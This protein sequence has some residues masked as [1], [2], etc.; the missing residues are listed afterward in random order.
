MRRVAHRCA[1]GPRRRRAPGAVVRAALV[2]GL[3]LLAGR[4]A[5]ADGP[6]ADAAAAPPG[7]PF[8]DYRS[9]APGHGHRI[10]IEDLPPPFATRSS[11]NGPRIVA[12]PEGVWPQVP[13]GFRVN[14]YAEHLGGPRVIRVAPNGDVFVAESRAGRIRV[15]RGLTRDGQPERSEVFAADLN[16]PYGLAFYPPG[17]EPR[18]LY[19]GDNDAVLRFPYAAGDLKASG[20]AQRLAELPHGFD[21]HWT[22]DLRFSLDGRTLFVGVGS[23]S[24]LDD[25]DT[26]AGEA[27]RANILAFDPDGSRPRIYASGTRNPSGLAVDPATGRL[28][29]AVNER[30]GLGDDL[31]PDYVTAVREG[32]FY[33]WPWWYLGAH[34]DPRMGGRHPELKDRAI[35]PDVLLQAHDA[36]L[37]LEFYT[38]ARFPERYRGDLFVTSHGS[39]N[40]SVR[41]GY[42]LIRISLH[43]ASRPQGDYEDFLTGFVLPGGDVWGRP[44]GVAVAADGALLV[45]DDAGNVIW[46]IDYVAR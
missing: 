34:P 28:W 8:S 29:C 1:C 4:A 20:E 3:A 31:V 40:R 9:E 21:G 36:P 41:T 25:P 16:R 46:R 11:S 14:Q 27:R 37:Q 38:G 13:P 42:E 30:D 18:W 6:D 2:A 17:P 26:S 19:V 45:S 43:Q 39:W 12:R 44:V 32:G 23:A 10:G 33:G 5:A 7:S 22:R 15:F 24:N 35:V